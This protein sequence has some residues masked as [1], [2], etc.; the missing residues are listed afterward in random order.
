M[1]ILVCVKQVPFEG[2]PLEIREDGLWIRDHGEMAYTMNRYDEHAMEEAVSIADSFPGVTVEAVSVGPPRVSQTLRRAL[3]FGAKKGVHILIPE[4]SCPTPFEI[5]S[6]IAR[7]AEGEGYDLIFAGVM[8]EDDMQCLVGPLLAACLSIPCQTAAIKTAIH[9]EER[10]ISIVSEVEGGFHET[11]TLTLPALVTV[12]SGINTPRYPA[13][14]HVL[15][16]K[17]QALTVI[18]GGAG[19]EPA[20]RESV[21]GLSFPERP[22]KGEILKGLPEEKAEALL[23][24]LHE[25]SLL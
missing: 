15:R 25:Q 22:G 10:K 2:S 4:D 11:A 13:L 21:W 8:A 3:A 23:T 20:P 9:P 17:S 7:F 16:S 5:A 19:G 6:H 24:L 18:E 1:R 14:S 12:Q